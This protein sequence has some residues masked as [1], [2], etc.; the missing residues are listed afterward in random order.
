MLSSGISSHPDIDHN[1]CVEFQGR[2]PNKKR[3]KRSR[4][5][6]LHDVYAYTHTLSRCISNCELKHASS[7]FETRYIHV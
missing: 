6:T 4:L 7:N 3:R 5:F 2:P 1:S